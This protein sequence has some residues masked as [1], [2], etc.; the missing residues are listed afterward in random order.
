M[1]HISS[2]LQG[3]LILQLVLE[4]EMDDSVFAKP[5]IT[6]KLHTKGMIGTHPALSHRTGYG[7]RKRQKC[8]GYPTGG[9]ASLIGG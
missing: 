8:K 6:E 2:T 1:H 3:E 7:G 9:G 4:A 5:R